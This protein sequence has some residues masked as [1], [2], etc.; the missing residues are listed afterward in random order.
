MP[1]IDKIISWIL[2]YSFS[3]ALNIPFHGDDY[4]VLRFVILLPFITIGFKIS[5]IIWS[6]YSDDLED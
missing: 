3:I 4:R 6:Y 2:I 1:I 5:N